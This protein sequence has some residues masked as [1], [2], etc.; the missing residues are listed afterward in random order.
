MAKETR[1]QLPFDRDAINENLAWRIPLVLRI[2]VQHRR[3]LA[4]YYW[5]EFLPFSIPYFHHGQAREGYRTVL[6]CPE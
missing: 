3:S 2:F 1:K 6:T 4:M 5:A